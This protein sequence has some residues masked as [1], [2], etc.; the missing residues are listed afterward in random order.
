MSRESADVLVIGGGPAGTTA[1]TMLKRTNPDRRV[2]L[3]ERTPFPR[4]HV[5]ESTLP[6]MN[7]I[8]RR[9]GVLRTIDAAGFVRKRGITY[10]WAHDKPVFS[11]V[12]STGV[13]DSLVR[14]GGEGLPDYAWQIDRSR[15]DHILLEHAR[16]QGVEIRQPASV[17]S[18]LREGDRVTGLRV[19]HEGTETTWESHFVVDASGQARVLSR[20]LGL[21]KDVHA[22]GDL[23]IYRYYEGF[24]W[25]ED[26]IGAEDRSKIFFSATPAGWMWFIPL[27][28]RLVSVGLVTRRPFLQSHEPSALF[29]RELATVPEMQDMLAEAAQTSAPGETEPPRTHTIADWSYSHANP[30]GPGWYLA[31]DAAAFVDP[32]LSSGILLAHHSGLSVSNAINTEWHHPDISV[33]D[34]HAGYAT[35]YRDLYGGFLAMARWWYHRRG[36]A[37]IDEWLRTAAELGSSARGAREIN[38]DDVSA[39]MTFAAGFLTDFRFV[40]LGCA[41]GDRGLAISLDG[42]ENRSAAGDPLRRELLDRSLRPHS[43][44]ERAEVSAYVAT[45]VDSDRFWR[46]PELRFFGAFGERVYRPPVPLEG[47]EERGIQRTLQIVERT[48]SS[49]NGERTVDDVVRRVRDSFDRKDAEAIQKLANLVLSDLRLLD[50]VTLS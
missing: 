1:A 21:S 2:V 26:L 34:L 19:S 25:R 27:S 6:D 8:L 37:G 7:P 9:L 29:D 10:K 20:W 38:R 31:G 14:D 46:L 30:A 17:D 32:I 47:R 12:F 18:V 50:A 13:L 23:A 41:F 24:R 35:F 22:L 49:C 11:E 48:L 44:V 33:E 15:Y 36:V 42:L 43:R 3:F 39:F 5:G 45:D 16:A 4:H 28:S 40:H